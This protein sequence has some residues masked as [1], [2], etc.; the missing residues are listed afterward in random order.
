MHR[1]ENKDHVKF[2]VAGMKVFTQ[3][4]WCCKDSVRTLSRIVENFAYIYP[5]AVW[6]CY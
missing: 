6:G 2:E 3:L 1:N 4:S 5:S